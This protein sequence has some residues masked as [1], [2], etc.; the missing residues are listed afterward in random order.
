[1]VHF[2]LKSRAVLDLYENDAASQSFRLQKQ[3][4]H[5]KWLPIYDMFRDIFWDLVYVPSCVT[6]SSVTRFRPF[7]APRVPADAKDLVFRYR[8][9]DHLKTIPSVPPSAS[10]RPVLHDTG[11]HVLVRCTEAAHKA[12]LS[13]AFQRRAAQVVAASA[14]SKVTPVS[15]L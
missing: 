9:C 4:V 3:V 6:E 12:V 11:K 10:H 15:T 2:G 1:M 14:I 8:P 13:D 7:D 5:D